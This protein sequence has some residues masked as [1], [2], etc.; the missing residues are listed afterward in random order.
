MCKVKTKQA[1]I[2]SGDS[3]I[4]LFYFDLNAP[5]LAWFKNRKSAFMTS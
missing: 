5:L 4:F 2:V 1:V 3:N